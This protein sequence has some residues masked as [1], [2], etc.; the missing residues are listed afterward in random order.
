MSFNVKISLAYRQCMCYG[1]TMWRWYWREVHGRCC[2]LHSLKKLSLLLLL[3]FPVTSHYLLRPLNMLLAIMA[4]RCLLAGP[5]WDPIMLKEIDCPF[6]VF[7]SS[8]IQSISISHYK[9]LVLNIRLQI[10]SESYQINCTAAN[11]KACMSTQLESYFYPK[12]FLCHCLEQ[13]TLMN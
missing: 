11:I 2:W 4:F 13:L 12:T 1:I 8:Y 3:R 5:G 9:S 7:I 10:G 6:T